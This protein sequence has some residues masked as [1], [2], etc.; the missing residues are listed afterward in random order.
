M[1]FIPNIRTI[2]SPLYARLRKKPDPWNEELTKLVQQIKGIAKTLPVLGI[3]DP[4]ASLIVETDAS[5]LGYSGILKQVLPN[6]S[7]EQIVRYYSGIWHESQQKYSTVKKE[8]L[9]IVL[10][11][12]KIYRLDENIMLYCKMTEFS[13]GG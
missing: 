5:E 2:C 11:L 7:K 8:I 10:I 3:P 9:A 13:H 4:E 12:Q 1:D 6:S